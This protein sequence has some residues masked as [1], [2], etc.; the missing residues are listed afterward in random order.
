MSKFIDRPRYLCALGGA[1]STLQTLP[2]AVPILHAS[3]GCG[4]NISFA[5]NYAAGYYGSSYCGGQAL[6]SSNVYENEIVFGG[7]GRLEEQ[8]ENT[9]KVIDGELYFVLTGC[10]VEMIGDDARGVAKKFSSGK[11]SVLAADTGGF[12]GNSF[13]GY[14]IVLS[15]LFRDFVVKNA[16]KN[17]K[18]LNLWGVV[19]LQDVFWKGNLKSLKSILTE[20]GY[21]VNT[22]FGEGETLD[23]LRN[24]GAAAMNIVVSDVYGIE[25]AKVFE[26]IHGVPYITVPFPIGENGTEIFIREIA[27]ALGIEKAFT[28]KVIRKQ[29]ARYY[30]YTERLADVYNDLDLQRYAVIVADSNYAQ[31]LT[32]YASD[33]LGWLPEL[34]V[35]TDILTDEEKEAVSKRFSNYKSGL[36][37]EVVFDTDTS[38]VKKYLNA[39]WP[40]N[41]GQKYYNSF[42]PAFIFGSSFERDLADEL[43]IPSISVTYPISNRLVLDRAYA[44]YDGALRLT[45][46]VFST[47]LGTR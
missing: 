1:I 34:V 47:L 14:D 28:E 25:P 41:R 37:P 21:H 6:P 27:K 7:E 19:P 10:M 26:E 3:A 39:H 42:S 2:K 44:G 32:R 35:I 36:K 24:S 22:F 8:I 15:T 9:L 23:N 43:K 29:K 17:E 12:H 18:L 33:D 38:S 30:S 46:D 31:A 4:S 40:N 11:V 20:L 16:F 5:L 45:E 13:K